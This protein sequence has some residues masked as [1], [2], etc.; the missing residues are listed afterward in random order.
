MQEYLKL[1]GL[2]KLSRSSLKKSYK[3]L[4]KKYHPDNTETGNNDMFLKIQNA[5]EVLLKE[6][7]KQ[8]FIIYA[9]VDEI[10]NGKNIILFDNL[11]VN[12]SYKMLN[13]PYIFKYLNEKYK[14]ILKPI[15]DKNE[16]LV[17]SKGKLKL[18]RY[19]NIGEKHE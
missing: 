18:I 6:T 9:T 16:K 12:I 1:F 19:I 8:T 4:S 11:S 15:L 5:Y 7:I 17:Y 13:K 3:K 2:K 10:A 14:I